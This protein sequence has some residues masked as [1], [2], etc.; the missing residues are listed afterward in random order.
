MCIN[1]YDLSA[2]GGCW[3][4]VY[5]RRCINTLLNVCPFDCTTDVVSG[6]VGP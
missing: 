1:F 4:V 3:F 2:W 6:K 5:I